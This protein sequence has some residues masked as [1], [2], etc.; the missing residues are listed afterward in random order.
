MALSQ[1][2]TE[3][4]Q[5][6]GVVFERPSRQV[7]QLGGLDLFIRFLQ[8]GDF[9]E[10]LTAEFG[11]YKARSMLELMLGVIAGAKD[12]GDVE[13]LSKHDPVISRY[14]G[15]TVVATQLTRDFKSFTAAEIQALHDFNVKLALYSILDTVPLSTRLTIDIDATPVRKYGAQEGVVHGYVDRD[16]IKPCYQYLLFRIHELNIV[17]YGTIR[18]GNT[19]SQNGIVDYLKR[20]LPLMG[21]RWNVV[22]RMDSGFFNEEVFDVA[23]GNDTSVFVKA[24]MSKARL[25]FAHQSKE[26]VWRINPDDPQDEW[27]YASHLT[28]TAKGSAWRELFKRAPLI[29]DERNNELGLRGVAGYRY[30]CAATNDL[31]LED[32]KV[33][34]EYNGRANVENTIKEGKYDFH[35]GQIVTDQFDA[36]DVITQVTIMAYNLMAHLKLKALPP[37][38]SKLWL[39]TLRTRLFNVPAWIGFHAKKTCLRIHNAFTTAETI[40][41]IYKRIKELKSLVLTPPKSDPIKLE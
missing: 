31:I 12:M 38:M 17:F 11:P 2:L 23:A 37:S 3:L 36:N 9:R 41:A 30:E 35:L 10:R 33:F 22:V 14:L 18:S 27:E 24:P 40:A 34:P 20:F 28:K 8:R 6:F 19:H 4:R 7:S 39:S 15:N 16:M 13:A 5:E 29:L 25:S 21:Q 32:W 26:L 1:N